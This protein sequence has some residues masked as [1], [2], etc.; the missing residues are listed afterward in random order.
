MVQVLLVSIS[1]LDQNLTAGFK[2][3]LSRFLLFFSVG[4][5]NHSSMI[6]VTK[7]DLGDFFSSLYVN[8]NHSIYCLMKICPLLFRES[9]DVPRN[10]SLWNFLENV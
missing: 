2:Q 8:M 5:F 6:K 3:L 4:D 7:F 10:L 1:A 9:S